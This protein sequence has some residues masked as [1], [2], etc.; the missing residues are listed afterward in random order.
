M[1][2]GAPGLPEDLLARIVGHL[3]GELCLAPSAVTVERIERVTWRD[4]SLGCPE[5][6]MAYTQ[7]LVDGF[8]V[9]VAV[10]EE[11]FDY[12]TGGGGTFRRCHR[13]TPGASGG[14][15]LATE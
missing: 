12:R 7:A 3:A 5:P 15:G 2:A 10:G 9:I 4:G 8:R 6:G 1:T 13:S 14:W 11:R